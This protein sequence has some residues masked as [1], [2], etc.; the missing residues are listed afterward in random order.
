MNY[1]SEKHFDQTQFTGRTRRYFLKAIRNGL[2]AGGGLI[3]WT[4]LI[5]PFWLD[6]NYQKLSIAN[7][8]KNWV[9]KRLIQISDLHAGAA[10]LDYLTR[11]IEAVNSIEPDVVVITG[12]MID[13]TGGLSDLRRIFQSLTP[14][15]VT[16]LGC[17]GNHDYGRWFNDEATA[18]EVVEIAERNGIQVLRNEKLTIDGL[19]FFG[20]EDPWSPRFNSRS[21]ILLREANS[22]RPAIC[23][24]H[25]PDVCDRNLWGGFRG[26]VLAGHTHG[27]QCKPPFLPAPRLPVINRRYTQGFFEL[28]ASRQL[29]ISRGIGYSMQVRFN[30]RPEITV[31]TLAE[32]GVW[33][34]SELTA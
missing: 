7:L 24:C 12:D 2:V 15:R 29:Y 8:P 16:T 17:L 20:M 5:E 32:S 28:D 4:G 14:A 26:Y 6:I 23:L 30:C 10:N 19:D 27:G 31:F 13:M 3:G 18:Q 9:G 34:G 1:S 11:A 22:N 21:D 33:D 25:N